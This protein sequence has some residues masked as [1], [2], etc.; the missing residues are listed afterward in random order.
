MFDVRPCF[1]VHCSLQSTTTH[2]IL[3]I[4]TE[5]LYSLFCKVSSFKLMCHKCHFE[6]LFCYEIVLDFVH[7]WINYLICKNDSRRVNSSA[8]FSAEFI[9]EMRW[10]KSDCP[11]FHPQES[12]FE[13]RSHWW[14]YVKQN[15]RSTATRRRQSIGFLRR[16]NPSEFLTRHPCVSRC[17]FSSFHFARCALLFLSVR[18]FPTILLFSLLPCN[19]F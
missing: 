10:R 7:S 13:Y 14:L 4:S 2:L 8:L 5:G 18:V 6:I 19:A 3:R 17:S 12:G 11:C 16:K 15:D 1:D 9:T